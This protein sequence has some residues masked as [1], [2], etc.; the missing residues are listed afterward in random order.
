MS[1]RTYT[2]NGFETTLT[3]QLSAGAT[4]AQLVTTA[5]LAAPCYLLIE[6]DVPGNREWVR[7]NTIVDGTNISNI[8]R[9]QSGSVGDIT[10]PASSVVR[11]VFTKQQL[12]AIFTDIEAVEASAATNTSTITDH[13]TDADQHPE[14]VQADGTRDF[15]G[16]VGGVSGSAATDFLTK[17]QIDAADTANASAITSEEAARISADDAHALSTNHP[18]ASVSVQGMMSAADK[19]IVDGVSGHVDN[20]TG[21]PAAVSGG[22]SGFLTGADKASLDALADE[23]TTQVG[24]DAGFGDIIMNLK[25]VGKVVVA[26]FIIDS[27]ATGIPIGGGTWST[28]IPSGY[29]PWTTV[30][31]YAGVVRG[32]PT[33]TTQ[34]FG[35]HVQTDGD[36]LRTSHAGTTQVSDV[37]YGLLTWMT[38]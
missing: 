7:V 15:T 2:W 22:A 37:V 38:S 26:D 33:G 25:R 11:G 21:H 35:I 3:A 32:G 14:Y 10:H 17:A 19:V 16:A 28:L 13:T 27:P 31:G 9:N 29:R 1:S 12:D 36:V 6:A 30:Q 4:S 34:N 8:V 20:T 23:A 5:G 24:S 18:T